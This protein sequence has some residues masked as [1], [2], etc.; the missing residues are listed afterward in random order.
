MNKRV[1]PPWALLLDVTLCIFLLFFG[2][3]IYGQT[4]D[5]NVSATT[6]LPQVSRDSLRTF[7]LGKPHGNEKK[8]VPRMTFTG[9][10]LFRSPW[11]AVGRSF[12]VNGWGQWY[13]ERPMK[14]LVFLGADAAMIYFYRVKNR[15]VDKIQAQR[16]RID[17]QLVNDPFL[18][19][20]QKS[21]LRSRF[22]NLTSDLDGA[23]TDRNLYGWLFAISHLMGMIDAYVDAH[24]FNFDEKMELAYGTDGRYFNVA[25]RITF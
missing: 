9:D 20:E 22:S 8:S 23:L 14:G 12:L 7:L 4:L 15:K 17:R 6:V 25:M 18:T 11:G 24:L 5:S 3:P 1:S 21:I 13:N 2:T 16:K 10:T 19:P